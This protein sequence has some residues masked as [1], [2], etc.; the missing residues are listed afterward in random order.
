MKKIIILV[1]ILVLAFSITKIGYTL[2]KNP[3]IYYDGRK[4]QIKFINS[5]NKDLFPELK[6]LM[7]GDKKEQDIS[8]KIRNIS[9][10][11][12]L[13]IK[14]KNLDVLPPYITIKTY[15][16]DREIKPSD[17]YIKLGSFSEETDI[18][19]K[20]VVTVPKDISNEIENIKHEVVW[21]FLAQKENSQ[22]EEIPETNDNIIIYIILLITSL[23]VIIIA[24]IKLKDNK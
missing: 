17:E 24:I 14:I 10:V 7:P 15:I 22:I 1:S 5:D 9:D 21:D 18:D 23:I 8:L 4:N 20:V 3:T 16:D 12:T 13:F 2:E 19:I 11:T 6:N